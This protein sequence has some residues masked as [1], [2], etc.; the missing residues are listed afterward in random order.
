MELMFWRQLEKRI[1]D[2]NL[3]VAEMMLLDIEDDEEVIGTIENG[4][5]KKL[6]AFRDKLRE[7][8]FET[9]CEDALE[10][11]RD[12]NSSLEGLENPSGDNHDEELDRRDRAQG[13]RKNRT[14]LQILRYKIV[15]QLCM[16]V[17]IMQFP[18]A[19]DLKTVYFRK[20]WKVTKKIKPQEV[21]D[22]GKI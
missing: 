6:L 20:G 10:T 14:T 22:G 17:I 2:V 5:V 19:H 15:E 3:G 8:T 21:S 18:E 13:A 9:I 16:A 7:E 12:L 1:E 4:D 11:L